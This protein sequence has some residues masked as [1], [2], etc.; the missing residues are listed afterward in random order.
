M[1]N[2]FDYFIKDKIVR[3]SVYNLLDRLMVY[4]NDLKHVKK[5]NPSNKLSYAEYIDTLA[6]CKGQKP[7]YP[8][9][10]SGMGNGALV[11]LADG[12]VKYDFIC[13]IGAHWGHSDPDIIKASLVVENLEILNFRMAISN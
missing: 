3:E 8:Y 5:S 4:Q 7:F 10:S 9:L 13:G 6:T 12:S 2:Q 1:A 11:E